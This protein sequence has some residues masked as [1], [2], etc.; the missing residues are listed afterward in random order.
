MGRT[1]PRDL[2]DFWYLVEAERLKLKEHWGEFQRKAKHKGQNPDEFAAKVLK[3][4]ATFKR[5]WDK[6]FPWPCDRSICLAQD[7]LFAHSSKS[8]R[9]VAFGS[10]ASVIK[11]HHTLDFDSRKE[12]VENFSRQ[13]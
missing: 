13:R 5:D 9:T 3:K 6:K 8:Q 1:E 10:M 7:M 12:F 2:Y 4:E 11:I